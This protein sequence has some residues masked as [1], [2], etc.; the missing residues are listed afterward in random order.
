MALVLLWFYYLQKNNTP[1]YFID[2]KIDDYIPFKPFF[3][4]PYLSWFI[5][6]A[7]A[8]TYFF[9]NSR[10]DFVRAVFFIFCGMSVS[11]L[12]YTLF[13]SGNRLRPSLTD[14]GD[15]LS[16]RIVGFI[17]AL[18]PPNNCLP[19]IHVLN[20]MGIHFSILYSPKFIHM[21]QL[22]CLSA[23]LMVL[24]CLSTVFIKQH[25]AAD[26]ISAVFLGTILYLLIYMPRRRKSKDE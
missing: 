18:D 4:I 25:S 11:M 6:M 23:L 8:L 21:R 15:S 17:Y 2:M 13:P 19:S 26:V 5:Y 12:C 7:V 10:K 1:R 14:A 22:K 24:I 20:T 3:V 9:K 16:L